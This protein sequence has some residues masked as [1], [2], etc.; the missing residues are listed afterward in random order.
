VSV[1]LRPDGMAHG[2]E[3]VAR[4]D[5][6]ACFVAGAIPG[7]AVTASLVEDRGSWSRYA[8]DTVVEASPDRVDPPCPHVASCGGC[9]WQHAAVEAQRAW[10][11]SI[12]AGQLAHL[13]GIAEPP[14]LPTVAAGPPFGYRNRMDF[15]VVDGRPG[16]HRYRSDE[17]SPIEACL[18]L[19]PALAELFS[20]LGDVSGA[21]RITL[22]AGTTTG[23]GLIVVSGELPSGSSQWPAAVARLRRGRIEP[24]TGDP[25]IEEVVANV[26]FRIGGTAFFQNNTAGAA[27]LVDL[28]ERALEP[29]STDTLLDAFAG[30]GLFA[31]T[32][33]R[34]AGRVIGIERSGSAAAGFRHNLATSDV[35]GELWPGA[36]ERVVENADE[37]W[38]IAVCDPPRRGLRARGVDAITAARPRRIAYVSC[39][40]ASLGRDT[41]LLTAAGYELVSATPVDLFPQTFHVETVA[42][43][44]R[45]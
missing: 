41:R 21:E 34:A 10:K 39:D 15:A 8:I 22:R 3:A 32:V 44:D 37:Y 28:V 31:L 20:Q 42:R 12:V 19:V 1:E 45:R 9:Q 38:D 24:V 36:V 26:R 25:W 35:A 6:K 29:Q 4:L 33:G 7:E 30:V 16:L 11:Q 23:D 13:G 17:I 27:V 2:G 5:G 18:L 43:F 40:P 14:V